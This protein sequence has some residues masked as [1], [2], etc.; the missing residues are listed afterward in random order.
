ATALGLT[1]RDVVAQNASQCFDISVWQ[2]LVGL[3]LGGRI[4][5]FTDDVVRD[6][7]GMLSAACER[8]VT[9]LEVVPS[10]MRMALDDVRSAPGRRAFGKRVALSTLRW[11]IPT[12]EAISPALC[13][14][15]LAEFPE[16]PLVN[17]YGPTECADDV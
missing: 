17:A 8:G 16:V 9:V 3:V 14:E 4:E 10:F 2:L 13:R 5:I 11:L 15:W 1:E 6:P 12:G 7:G